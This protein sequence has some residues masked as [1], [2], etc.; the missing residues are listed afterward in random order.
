MGIFLTTLILLFRIK[1]E[2]AADAEFNSGLTFKG[3]T[4]TEPA[5]VEYTVEGATPVLNC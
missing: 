5:T 2:A 3:I 4:V 1:E